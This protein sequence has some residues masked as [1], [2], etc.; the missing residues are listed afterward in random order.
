MRG[1]EGNLPTLTAIS[2]ISISIEVSPNFPRNTKVPI[3]HHYHR[4]VTILPYYH[5]QF[6]KENNVN[7]M[8]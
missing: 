6:D 7:E 8:K 1:K 4:H 2:E 3:H 5:S